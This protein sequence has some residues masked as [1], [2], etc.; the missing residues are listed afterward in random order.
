[1]TPSKTHPSQRKL[2]DLAR[3]VVIP[4]GIE[5]TAWP[6][7][8]FQL[9]RM[10]YPLDRWQVGVGQLLFSKRADGLYSCGIGGAIISIPRQVGKTHMM[11][12]LIFALCVAQPN[13]L[14]L[15][16]AH[17][18][19]THNET[20]GS[21]QGVANRP[22]IS[23]FIAH[24][25]K[26][27]G[28]E[29]IIFSNGSR[30]LFGAREN[31]FGRG[32]AEVDVIV[33][34]EAQI[35]TEK[36]MEDMVPATNAAPNGL[37]ILMGTP[38]RPNDPGEVFTN[39]RLAALAGDKDI[40]YVEFSAD[41]DGNIDSKRQWAK[42][43]PSFP[44][45]TTESAIKRMRKLLGSEDAFRRE[46]LGIWDKVASTTKALN[47]QMWNARIGN[48]PE[49]GVVAFGVKFS[50]D[51]A[52]V[53]LAAAMKPDEGPIFVEVIR[54]EPISTGTQWLVDFLADRKDTAA[55]IT[56]DGK[57]G[58]GDLINELKDAG[59][60]NKRMLIAPNLDQV[61]SAHTMFEQ[62]VIKGS[63][64]HSDQKEFTQQAITAEKRKIGANGGFGWKPPEGGSCA[65]LDAA[66]LAFWGAKTTRRRPGRKQVVS[67]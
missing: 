26:G 5:T 57:S 62:A 40:L 25:R 24:V 46:G 21:M 14:V 54:S 49:D 32:F 61:I 9:K 16:S 15:W 29:A 58:A 3:H 59:I 44:H 2:S 53:A 37:V 35:L 20:F 56:I 47:K 34:D 8:A 31:G 6:K 1:M 63:L 42:A 7:I 64:T 43:N 36:A 10:H 30:I 41:E 66:T 48:A 52:E 50:S 51:G 65:F 39:S 17:R 60:K 13:T 38:P 19:R 45:R 27:A 4:E 28:T 22:A 55:Q 23:P 11:A 33:M 67:F 12:G 18:A